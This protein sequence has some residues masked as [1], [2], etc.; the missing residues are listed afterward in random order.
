V[1]V[2]V[3]ATIGLACSESFVVWFV[4]LMMISILGVAGPSL[5]GSGAQASPR[6]LSPDTRPS[7]KFAYT[8]IV[9]LLIWIG[10]CLSPAHILIGGKPR[11]DRLLFGKRLPVDALKYLNQ[12][13]SNGLILVP[14]YWSDWI[15]AHLR[16]PV[17]VNDD[18]SL[19]P[20]SVISDYR[21][22]YDGEANWLQILEKYDL[23]RL[24]IDKR[25]Q[26]R[27]LKNIRREA[28]GWS[29]AYE[30]EQTV[31]LERG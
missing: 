11:A 20:A 26:Q 27:L 22:V 28:I 25:A 15:Q 8:L 12:S 14:S 30:D 3:L 4:P 29:V 17:F 5:W 18:P 21:Q 9:G 7:M 6:R 13:Q 23:E 16:V 2:A 24:M 19:V 10:F 31:V 1:L